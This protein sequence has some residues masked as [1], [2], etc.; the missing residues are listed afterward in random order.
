[1]LQALYICLSPQMCSEINTIVWSRTNE[2]RQLI[3]DVVIFALAFP[4]PLWL[5]FGAIA[6]S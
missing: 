1:M 6:V 2:R 5:P 4:L 3:T